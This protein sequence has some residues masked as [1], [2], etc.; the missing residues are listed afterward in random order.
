MIDLM[1]WMRAFLLIGFAA[2]IVGVFFLPAALRAQQE[3]LRPNIPPPDY[4][5]T[6]TR[7]QLLSTNP[8]PPPDT[9]GI[10]RKGL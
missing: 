3:A 4:P 2:A 5:S 7:E 6:P 10:V 1:F 8:P 9:D